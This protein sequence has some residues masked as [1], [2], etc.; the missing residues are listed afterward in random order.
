MLKY[1]IKNKSIEK[2]ESFTVPTEDEIMWFHIKNQ[3]FQQ[4]FDTILK[5]LQIHP[6]SKKFMETFSD[7]PKVNI[8]KNEAVISIF[9]IEE[10]F[11]PVKINILVG[12]NFIITREQD[13]NLHLL[14][15]IIKDFKENPE[16]MSHTGYILYQIIQKASHEFLHAVDEIADEIQALEKS[17]FKD[18]FE[19]KIGKTAYRWKARLHDL[20][21][22]IEP[23][24]SVL[25]S[26]GQSEFPY[27]NEDSGFYFQ[28]LQHNYARIINAFDT[29]IENMASIFNLQLSLKSDHTNTIMKTL[30]L[31]SVIFIPM[32]FIAG[33][34]GM[35]FEN[36]PELKWDYGYF[37]VLIV[38][39]GLGCGIA[40]YFRNKGWWGGKKS[41]K[42]K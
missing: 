2:V 27:I 30:T 19:N 21:Q 9:S 23:Q 34:Y 20:R 24:E 4:T 38:I 1:N 41:E 36:M 26:I 31:V 8:Y 37:Y 17:V 10:N 42:T 6:L 32:T 18:P 5:E 13:S 40:L 3:S 14:S 16:H 28:D 7:I 22:I 35:N 11:E 39:F 12:K 33:L 25:Q 15:E 29:F